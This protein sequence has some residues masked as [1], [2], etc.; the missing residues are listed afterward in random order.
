MSQFLKIGLAGGDGRHDEK[1]GF[2]TEIIYR[3]F[4]KK[5]PVGAG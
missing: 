4:P 5:S 1:N 2:S 3:R